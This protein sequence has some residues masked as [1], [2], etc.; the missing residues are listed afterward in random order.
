MKIYRAHFTRRHRVERI[1][2]PHRVGTRKIDAQMIAHHEPYIGLRD[3]RRSAHADANH[4]LA[5][6]FEQMHRPAMLIEHRDADHFRASITKTMVDV[7]NVLHYLRSSR[8][9]ARRIYRRAL[10]QRQVS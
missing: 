7:R 8:R 9:L 5:V 4:D 10:L 3:F 1:G 6:W 2:F